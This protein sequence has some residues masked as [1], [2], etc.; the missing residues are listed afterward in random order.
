MNRRTVGIGVTLLF[1]LGS[2][3]PAAALWCYE[4][5]YRGE[6]CGPLGCI[7][8]YQCTITYQVCTLCWDSCSEN[9]DGYCVIGEQCE[10]ADKTLKDP[11][12]PTSPTGPEACGP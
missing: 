9:L 6:V 7:P 5:K 3:T 4:C 8:N 10:W 12:K 11:L 1:A 2:L